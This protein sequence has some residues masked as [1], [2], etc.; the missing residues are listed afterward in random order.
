M[1]L[2]LH[3]LRTI[4][5]H[6]CDQTVGIEAA[7]MIE[8]QRDVLYGLR[9]QL[10]AARLALVQYGAH[11][12]ACS[13]CD[14]DDEGRHFACDCGYEAAIKAAEDKTHNAKGQRGAACGASAAPTGC[15]SNGNYNERTDK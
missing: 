4:G 2:L 7:E 9:Q 5:L 12:G 8:Q 1:D 3:N 14:L 13:V 15:A 6:H 10:A 11:D